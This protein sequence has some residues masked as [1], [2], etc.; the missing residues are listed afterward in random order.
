MRGVTADRILIGVE[1]ETASFSSDEENL[2]MR[3]VIAD[4]NARGGIHGRRLEARGYPRSGG[5]AADESLAN[6]R[7]LID[8]GVFLLFNMGGP[9]AVRIAPLAMNRRVPYMFPHTALLTQDADRY[10]FT[11]FPRF[12]GETAVLL[13][14]VIW[15]HSEFR[16][17]RFQP[18]GLGRLLVVAEKGFTG[19]F[20]A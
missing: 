20:A 19:Q 2:G 1:A 11:S 7:R 9:A 15:R 4:V 5:A 18:G 14:V 6:A 17:P 13:D 8:D 12:A 3:L 16:M 10:V